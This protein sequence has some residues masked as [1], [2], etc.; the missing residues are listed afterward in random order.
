MFDDIGFYFEPFQNGLDWMC[1]GLYVYLQLN[2]L[3]SVLFLCLSSCYGQTLTVSTYIG[4]TLYAI[5]LAV[6]GLVLFALLIGNVQVVCSSMI[7]IQGD[8]DQVFHCMLILPRNADVPAIY[9]SKGGGM[10]A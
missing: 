10:E 4:E 1:S 3:T 8:I 2:F 9:H 6:V 5:S 7:V